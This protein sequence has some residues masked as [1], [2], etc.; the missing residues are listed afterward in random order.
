[1]NN[2][3]FDKNKKDIL[4]KQDKSKKGDIDKRIADLCGIINSKRNYFTVSSCSGRIL[5]IAVPENNKKNRAEWLIVTHDLAT[6]ENFIK[7]LDSYNGKEAVYFKQEAPILHV[8]C[9]TVEDAQSLLE[10]AKNNGFKHSGI[11]SANKKT[12]VELIGS[13][14]IST[15]VYDKEKLIDD[16]Y[17]SYLISLANKK[18]K[19]SWDHIKRLEQVLKQGCKANT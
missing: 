14:I 9:R 16:D 5:L 10:T 13:E 7:A 11:F 19:I 18:L 4:R 3:D 1:M 17:M 12:V 6:T 2:Y 8:C 15:P